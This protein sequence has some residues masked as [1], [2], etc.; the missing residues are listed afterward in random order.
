MKI[1]K[2]KLFFS[3]LL[4]IFAISFAF[5]GDSPLKLANFSTEELAKLE[6]GEVLIRNIGNAKKVSLRPFCNTASQ[7]VNTIT[8]LRPPYLV[9]IIQKIPYEGNEEVF[10]ILRKE[11]TDVESYVG[12]PYFGERTGRWYKLYSSAVI[13]SKTEN[14]NSVDMQTRLEMSPF[15][16]IPTHILIEQGENELFYSSVNT[17]PV[18][19]KDSGVKIV[20]GMTCAKTEKMKSFV[21]AFKM[22]DS[23]YLYG[24]G[25][26]DAPNVPILKSKID[27]SFIN[28]VTTFCK[29]IFEK[30]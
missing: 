8:E 14:E 7:L 25:G 17:E 29:F 3:I 30:L 13:D 27:N 9:E 22:E 24:L 20:D 15:G 1:L 6:N 4:S 5:A 12:I 11:L 2:N 28:R 19:I 18:K 26:V 23:I 16:I 21:Y 10:D